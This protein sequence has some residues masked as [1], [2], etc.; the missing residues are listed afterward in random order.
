MVLDDG[1]WV[2]V[3]ARIGAG[4]FFEQAGVPTSDSFKEQSIPDPR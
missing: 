3:L 4:Y 1:F 2:T